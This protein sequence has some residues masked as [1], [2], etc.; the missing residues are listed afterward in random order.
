MKLR[1]LL[2]LRLR[3]IRLKWKLWAMNTFLSLSTFHNG[4]KY[5]ATECRDGCKSLVMLAF[6]ALILFRI[7]QPGASTSLVCVSLKSSQH[8]YNLIASN[9]YIK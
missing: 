6:L 1:V 8:R 9:K 5:E 4:G 2:Y 3:K 7:F